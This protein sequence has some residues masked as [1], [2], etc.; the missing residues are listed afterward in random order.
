MKI[1]IIINI[2]FLILLSLQ[3]NALN[4]DISK[5]NL[6]NLNL[7]KN[8]LSNLQISKREILLNSF[9]QKNT[10]GKLILDNSKAEDSSRKSMGP[11][12]G[13]GG[14]NAMLLYIMQNNRNLLNLLENNKDF[15]IDEQRQEIKDNISTAMFLSGTNLKINS[16][17]KDAR[18]FPLEKVIIFSEDFVNRILKEQMPIGVCLLLHEYLGLTTREDLNDDDFSISGGFCERVSILKAEDFSSSLKLNALYSLKNSYSHN[19]HCIVKI[20]NEVAAD[21][22]L[23]V[24]HER[25]DPEGAGSAEIFRDGDIVFYFQTYP[26]IIIANTL[27][28]N[29]I[30]IDSDR[31]SILSIVY[32][33]YMNK[34]KRASFSKN[35]NNKDYDIEC[36]KLK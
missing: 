34:G 15:F 21:L 35:F 4:I 1:E 6:N 31:S 17:D 26:S 28:L 33:L 8:K 25:G 24:I 3:S 12:T 29:E 11:R 5:S 36:I 7:S 16:E 23:S 22:N 9:F 14:G 20:D 19:V 32:N 10:N 30:P 27:S 2:V 18:Y 13:G